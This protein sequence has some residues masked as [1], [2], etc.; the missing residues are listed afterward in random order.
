ML[1]KFRRRAL[2]INFKAP[3]SG[4]D[5]NDL[6]AYSPRLHL[7]RSIKINIASFSSALGRRHIPA[8]HAVLC[9]SHRLRREDLR[10]L[11]TA[12]ARGTYAMTR[13]GHFAFW[14]QPERMVSDVRQFFGS[15]EA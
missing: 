12:H 5:R 14:E 13:R 2:L 10:P 4:Y 1:C 8:T 7:A 11:A 15:C 9:H 6:C 3:H